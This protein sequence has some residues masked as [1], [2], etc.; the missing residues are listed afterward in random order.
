MALIKNNLTAIIKKNS[1]LISVLF[2][3][4]FSI[5]ISATE[6]DNEQLKSAISLRQQ[7]QYQQAID[8]LEYLVKE[9][10]N[11]KRV[12]IELALNYIK[13][14]NIS[15][16]KPILS[17]LK[18]LDLSAKEH[19]KLAYLIEIVAEKK[20]KLANQHQFSFDATLY[21][22]S[23]HYTSKYPI[24]YI[25]EYDG[26]EGYLDEN[27]EL[28][29]DRDEA[30]TSKRDNFFAQK[31]KGKYRYKPKNQV[32]IFG[33][34]FKL[35]LSSSGSYYQRQ[36][37]ENSRP[38]Y[39][40][41]KLDAA[42]T[43]L[44]SEKW[45]FN[46]KLK[47]NVHFQDNNKVL[48]DNALQLSA[49]FP[50]NTSRVKLGY[51]YKKKHYNYLLSENNA[52]L[53]SPFIEYSIRFNDQYRFVVGSRYQKYSANN[54]FNDNHNV[55][56]Y[57]RLHYNYS[58]SLKLLVSYNHNSLAYTITSPDFVNNEIKNSWLIGL[59]Y[60]HNKHFSYGVN[61]YN[62]RYNYDQ[63]VGGNNFRR[64]EGFVKYSF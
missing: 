64:I 6:T 10:A 45:L 32:D 14:N 22:G 42:M 12:N 39:K 59:K 31:I 7:N 18:T 61:A 53:H 23:D 57:S 36:V 51:E 62:S 26:T 37:K 15:R 11:N 1:M 54:P 49:S 35:F 52:G 25:N 38:K 13:L 27:N 20:Q 17:H 28:V 46:F 8:I 48:N 40:L 41:I 58:D 44:S 16:S 34:K 9:H 29:E 3:L 19:Q 30:S 2:L 43:L 63:D 21:Y 5:K 4:F 50:F 33:E 56:L 60:N 55:S 24:Y 47:N